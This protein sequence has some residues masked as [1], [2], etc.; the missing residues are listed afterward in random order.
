MTDLVQLRERLDSL[1]VQLNAAKSFES[2]NLSQEIASLMNQ[3]REEERKYIAA[4]SN[5]SQYKSM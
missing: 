4:L 3:I 5:Q 1:I 2:V